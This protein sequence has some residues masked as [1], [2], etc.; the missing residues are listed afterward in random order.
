MHQKKPAINIRKYIQC[1]SLICLSNIS[2][3]YASSIWY[4]IPGF[5]HVSDGRSWQTAFHSLQIALHASHSGDQIWVA[6]G[7]YYPDSQNR[8]VSFQLK[9]NVAVYGGFK[10]NES[11]LSQRDFRK[12]ETILSGNI[13]KNDHSKNTITVVLGA[14]DAVLDGFT[15]SD[16]YAKASPRLHM[17]PEEITQGQVI[18]GGGMRNFFTSPIVRNCIFKNNYSPKGGAVYN[19]QKPNQKP[20]Q[21]INVSFINN[22]AQLRGGA[23]SN[24][25][26]SMPIFINSIFIHNRCEDKGGAIYN[27]FGSSPKIINALIESNSAISAGGLGNDGTSSP[28]LVNVTIH[29]NQATNLMGADLYQGTGANNNPIVINSIVKDVYNWHEDTVVALNSAISPGHSIPLATFLKISNLADMLSESDIS[30]YP[31]D[32]VG[33]QP[34]LDGRKLIT[35]QLIRK[36]DKF[37]VNNKGAILYLNS[38]QRPKLTAPKT[39]L[40]VL[41]VAP[42]S[43]S[44]IKDGSSWQTPMTDLQLAINTAARI[45]ATL[46]LKE[47]KYYSS[48]SRD[49]IAAFILYDNVKIYG[50]FRGD[51][52]ALSQRDP[53]KYATLLTG[54][55]LKTG[56]HYFHVLYGANNVELDGLTITGG[57][58]DGFTY[59]GKGGGLIAYP[60]GKTFLPLESGIGFTMHINNCRFVNNQAQEGGALYA[61]A[62]AKIQINNTTFENNKALYGGAILD[63]VGNQINCTGCKF[64]ANHAAR[65]GGAVYID[66]GSHANYNSA[67]FESNSAINFGGA[68]YVVSRASQLE[69]TRLVVDNSLFS[70]NKARIGVNIANMD[71]SIITINNSGINQ[72]SCQGKILFNN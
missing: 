4:V 23:V 21:F 27:D 10:G 19:L 48:N 3:S 46:W 50:G 71:Q 25:L 11:Q 9:D 38:Y 69:E 37:Y 47:G 24:D 33:Y 53:S 61:F 16:A 28:L 20:A 8:A 14:N 62:K 65:D 36:L 31:K 43:R 22:T 40:P 18:S 66:Y 26:G 51:E 60:A 34:K 49:Q 56:S 55:N 1:I 63:R 57:N 72:T 12:Y 30:A 54:T 70:H 15:I 45:N 32:K 58:A 41:F 6:K 67:T 42:A 13:N 2:Y 64:T 52:T 5:T 68:I 17:T 44:K 59:N 39:N 35:N 29:N 7:I